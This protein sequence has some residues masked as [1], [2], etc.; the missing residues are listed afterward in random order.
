MSIFTASTSKLSQISLNDTL[1]LDFVDNDRNILQYTEITEC[2]GILSGSVILPSTP[3]KYQLRGYD[4]QGNPFSHLVSDLLITFEYPDFQISLIGSPIVVVNPG[5]QSL[6]RMSVQNT[7]KGPKNLVISATVTTTAGIGVKFV[8]D[9]VLLIPQT[10]IELSFY[11]IAS[12]SVIE[13]QMLDLSFVV[14]DECTNVPTSMSFQAIV[15]TA[16]EFNVTDKTSKSLLFEWMPP[17]IPGNITSYTLSLDFVNRTITT[18]VFDESTISYLLESLVPYQ[19]VYVGITAQ[20]DS[21]ETAANAPIPI[22]TEES[23]K[24]I[25]TTTNFS[26]NIHVPC[27]HIFHLWMYMNIFMS[28]IVMF[29]ASQYKFEQCIHAPC[30]HIL[31]LGIF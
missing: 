1:Y 26:I 17:N 5:K 24:P 23:G 31:I 8:E 20:A 7:K 15:K 16:I 27:Q 19:L 6:V 14:T 12:D 9:D 22:R 4:I 13:G 21:N 30:M 10:E 29:N 25:P 3:L 28:Y 11:L 2:E 18:I